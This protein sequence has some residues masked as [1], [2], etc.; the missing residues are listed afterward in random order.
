MSRGVG[1]RVSLTS[2]HWFHFI[3]ASGPFFSS[4]G[5]FSFLSPSSFFLSFH[6]CVWRSRRFKSC[7]C[8]LLAAEAWTSY[9]NF[10]CLGSFTCKMGIITALFWGSTLEMNEII[11]VTF[12]T[13]HECQINIVIVVIIS[14]LP[15]LLWYFAIDGLLSEEL[16]FMLHI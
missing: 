8:L 15:E 7:L 1:G 13:H 11:H 12:F 5:Q 10:L 9:L 14:V 2:V 4:W 3:L 16:Y 6:K